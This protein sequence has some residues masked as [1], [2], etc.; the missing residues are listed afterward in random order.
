MLI[1]WYDNLVRIA[2]NTTYRVEKRNLLK[3]YIWGFLRLKINTIITDKTNN[4]FGDVFVKS[5]AD[6][7]HH[8]FV[9]YFEMKKVHIPD[10]Y[11]KR[12]T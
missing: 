5:Y 7:I 8:A 12:F 2:L 6:N 4:F 9:E 10:F 11:I 3:G 1:D